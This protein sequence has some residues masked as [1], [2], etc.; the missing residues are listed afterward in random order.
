MIDVCRNVTLLV[1]GLREVMNLGMSA[2]GLLRLRDWL[3]ASAL[4]SLL[5]GTTR[6]KEN[7]SIRYQMRSATPHELKLART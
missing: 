2:D 4:L 5:K 3:P 7:V 1:C 6:L